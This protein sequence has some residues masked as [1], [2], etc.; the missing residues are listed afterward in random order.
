MKNDRLKKIIF[1]FFKDW[2]DESIEAFF[3][4]FGILLIP[5]GIYLFYK[6]YK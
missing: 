2:S 4:V 6:E 5:L 1:W 3:S